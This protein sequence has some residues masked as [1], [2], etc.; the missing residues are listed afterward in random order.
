M[1]MPGLKLIKLRVGKQRASNFNI[2]E[3]GLPCLHDYRPLPKTSRDDR[4][5]E[6]SARWLSKT[7]SST[8]QLTASAAQR[9]LYH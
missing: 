7:A 1:Q 2:S 6:G 4:D 8:I 5:A 9:V 3:S